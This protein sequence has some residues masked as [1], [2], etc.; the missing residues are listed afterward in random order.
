M[1][2][3][4][5]IRRTPTKYCKWLMRPITVLPRAD[6][7]RCSI[8]PLLDAMTTLQSFACA[9]NHLAKDCLARIK[10]RAKP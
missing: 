6:W 2:C 1:K 4:F 9:G 5:L 3:P 7:N 10:E 8:C